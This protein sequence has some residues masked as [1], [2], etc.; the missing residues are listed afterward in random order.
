VLAV[1]GP[2]M[3]FLAVEIY[4]VHDGVGTAQLSLARAWP[5]RAAARA[6][7]DRKLG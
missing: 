7:D 3:T 2:W 6:W 5:P 4:V 1:Y